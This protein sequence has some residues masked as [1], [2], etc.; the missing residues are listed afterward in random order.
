MNNI[1]IAC[2]NLYKEICKVYKD[3]P[4]IP[5]SEW[6]GKNVDLS[7]LTRAIDRWSHMTML[8]W[9]KKYLPGDDNGSYT[10]DIL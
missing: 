8:T 4:T 3:F 6:S 7:L 1:S 10:K 2:Q 9:R 5:D